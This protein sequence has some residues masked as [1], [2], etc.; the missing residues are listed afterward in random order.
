MRAL[1]CLLL[2]TAGPALAA[3]EDATVAAEEIIVYGRAID[4]I[5]TAQSGSQGIVGYQDLIQRPIL[6]TGELLET[7]PGLIATQHSGEGKANQYYLRGFNLDHGT[8]FAGYVDAVPVNMRSHGHGQGYS[9]FNFVIPELVERI[10]YRKGPYWADV[11][12]FSAAG[13]AAFKTWDTLPESY[14]QLTAG[15]FGYARAVAAGS[16]GLGSGNLLAGVAATFDDGPWV[17]DSNLQQYTGLLKYSQ[18][19]GDQYLSVQ[20]G[21]YDGVW[22]ATDQV[23]ERAIDSGLI[24][25]FGYIDDTLGGSATRLWAVASGVFGAN[26]FSAYAV[27]SRFALTSN[28]TYFLEDPVLGDQFQ[29]AD[30]RSIFGGSY[31]HD[32]ALGLGG[33]PLTL[34]LGGDVRYDDIGAVGLYRSSRGERTRTV[35]EDSVGEFSIAGYGEAQWALSPVFRATLALRFDHFGYDVTSSIPENSGSGTANIVSPKVALAWRAAD[36]LELY[37]NYGQGYHSNDARGAA[38]S[39]DPNSL[40]PAEP[41]DLLVRATGAEIGGRYVSTRFNA[42]LVA[43]WLDLASEL[44]FIGDGGTTE[45]NPASRRFGIEF[46]SFWKPVDVLVIDMSGGWTDA[47]FRDVDPLAD[48]IPGAVQFVLAAG[49]TWDITPNIA[50]TLRVRHFGAA[51][52]TEDGSVTSDATTLVNFGAYW[53]AGPVRLS[54][55]IYNLF[56]SKVPDISYFYPSRLPGEPAEGVEDRHIHPAEPRQLRISARF[57]F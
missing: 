7:I 9:D 19:S 15:Q 14:V 8:D 17:L 39:L 28:F 20:I 3:D 50:A 52:L 34:T 55:D 32:F 51:P 25:R 13:T 33:R 47:H 43:F 36:G 5:G 42:T 24:D 11:G 30:S 48:R 56:D 54:F 26:R 41:V 2:L 16:T 23:P 12:D 44:L 46:S 4:L 6:R 22:N 35:R 57:S 37:A 38:I 18:G 31:A 29:Q 21:G 1:G 53:T 49:G 10:D 27:S 40:E 45:P